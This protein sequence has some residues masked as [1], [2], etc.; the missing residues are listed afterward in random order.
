[1]HENRLPDGGENKKKEKKQ[2]RFIDTN[3]E[4][5]K[6]NQIYL[7]SSF[8]ELMPEKQF[9]RWVVKR[10]ERRRSRRTTPTST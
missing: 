6:G 8:D 2:N 5:Q 7:R 4:K 10:N 1:M 9:L 3:A